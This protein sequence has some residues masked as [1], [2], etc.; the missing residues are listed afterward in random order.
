MLS[1][2]HNLSC[3][4]K[5]HNICAATSQ[6]IHCPGCSCTSRCAL[7]DHIENNLPALQYGPLEPLV[8]DSK[9]PHDA[10]DGQALEA[11]QLALVLLR[12]GCPCQK[13]GDILELEQQQQE[14]V[15][16]MGSRCVWWV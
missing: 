2:F 15:V 14:Q 10:N 1:T 12:A 13:G 6:L 8:V 9:G 4:G 16:V 5:V 3:D 7:V 11:N